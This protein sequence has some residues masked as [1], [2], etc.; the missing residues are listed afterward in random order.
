MI[1][2]RPFE[3]GDWP[4]LWPIIRHV[5]VA[6][7]TYAY[8]RD[9]AE[10]HARDLWLGDPANHVIVA[11]DPAV[12]GAAKFGPNRPGPGS[13]VANASFMVADAARGRGVGRLLGEAAIAGARAAGFAAMQF[14]AVVATNEA[15]VALWTKLGFTIVG[16]VPA[17]FEHPRLGRVPLLVMHRFL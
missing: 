3:Q 5:A 1:A 7:E 8:P 16:T 10:P 14:N 17:A 4:G 15:A 13:H 6:G 12:L 11:A 9:V 2:I